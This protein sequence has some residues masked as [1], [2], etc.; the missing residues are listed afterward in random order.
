MGQ[1][2]DEATG[3]VVTRSCVTNLRKGRIENPVYEK[4]RA[5]ARAMGFPPEAWFEDAPGDGAL[6]A[7]PE[8][9]DLA[10][11]VGHLFQ[12]IR[13]PRMGE[14]YTNAEA[15]RMSVGAHTE[16]DVEGKRIGQVTDPT[17]GQ[18]QRLRASSASSHPTLSTVRSSPSLTRSILKACATIHTGVCCHPTRD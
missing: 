12:T 10:S 6:A 14:P 1:R 11:R 17:V 5:I 13:H 9:Q 18:L 2:L 7:P 15:A 16:E 3:G 4:M 8:E